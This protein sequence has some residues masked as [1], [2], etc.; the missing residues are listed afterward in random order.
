MEPEEIERRIAE[1]EERL[2]EVRE[3][4]ERAL[5][6]AADPLLPAGTRHAVRAEAERLREEVL[7]LER[8]LIVYEDVLRRTDAASGGRREHGPES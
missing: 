6:Y 2:E 1:T 8:E 7:R 3:R 4:F 5:A